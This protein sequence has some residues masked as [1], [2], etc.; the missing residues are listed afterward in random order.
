MKRFTAWLHKKRIESRIKAIRRLRFGI[1]T[2][3]IDKVIQI[4]DF[5]LIVY[6]DNIVDWDKVKR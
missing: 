2:T 6:G 5:E 3:T 4:R 1:D